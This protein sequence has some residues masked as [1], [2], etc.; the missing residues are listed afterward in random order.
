MVVIYRSMFFMNKEFVKFTLIFFAGVF[1][2]A[3]QAPKSEEK[4][5]ENLEIAMAKCTRQNDPVCS[6]ADES[7]CKGNG[8]CCKDAYGRPRRSAARKVIEGGN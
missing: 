4:Q 5:E 1:C 7:Y 2:F 3:G 8:G 6:E